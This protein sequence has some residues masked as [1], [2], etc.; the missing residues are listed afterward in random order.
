MYIS[1]YIPFVFGICTGTYKCNIQQCKYK[2][3]FAVVPNVL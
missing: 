2:M 3:L 1:Y